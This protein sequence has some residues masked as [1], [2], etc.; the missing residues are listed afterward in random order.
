[1]QF[2]F[3]FRQFEGSEPLKELIR[4]RMENRLNKILDGRE[5]EIRVTIATEK[6]WTQIDVIVNALG[7]VFKCSEKTTDLY[8]AIDVVIDKL[9]RQ[10]LKRKGRVRERKRRSSGS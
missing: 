5:A 1:M 6:A 10:M 4:S 3:T 8:P 7:E 9:E 2:S